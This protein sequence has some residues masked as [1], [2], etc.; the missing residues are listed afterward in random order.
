[1]KESRWLRWLGPGVIAVGAGG[2]IASSAAG[3][4]QRPWAGQACGDESGARVAA[5]SEPG[6]I[7]LGDMRLEPWFRLDPRLD[8]AGALEGQRLAVGVDGDRSSRFMDLPPESFAA[9]PFG[10]IVLVGTDDGTTS[11]LEAVDVVAQCSWSVDQDAAVIRRGTIDPGGETIFEMR[12]DRTTRTDLGIWARPLSGRL[13]AVRVIEPISAD[14]RFGPTWTTEFAWDLSAR[15]LAIQSCGEAAC[16]TQV[17]DPAGGML[18]AVAE[19]DLGTMVGL[20]GDTLVTYAACP[21]LP[22]P[23]IATDLVT[24]TRAVLADAG[25]AAVAITTPDGPRLVHEVIGDSGV[26]LRSVAFDGSSATDLGRLPD[27]PR[28]I[29]STR[30]SGATT[31]VPSGWIVL[32]PDGGMPGSGPSAQTQLR[33]ISD[34]TTVQ[35]DEVAR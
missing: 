26:T 9:G 30:A 18:R 35:L 4:G 12:V 13:P 34:G 3:A 25:A 33:Q 10:R 15:S 2:L 27:G 19:P 22:C 7:G 5:A 6:P 24:G 21:G 16:R 29:P 23:I 14:E 28:L 17:V 32:G 20:D 8:G 31:R 1:V 11:R